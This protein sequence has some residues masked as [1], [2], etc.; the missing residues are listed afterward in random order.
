MDNK[1]EI[2]LLSR[3]YGLYEELDQA[4]KDARNVRDKIERTSNMAE[5]YS[6]VP[7]LERANAK[8]K[9]LLTEYEDIARKLGKM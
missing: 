1:E 2:L 6:L 5:K 7:Q 8:Y 3:Y 4:F 9:E